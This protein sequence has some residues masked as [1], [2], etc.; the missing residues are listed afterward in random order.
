ME[1]QG[2]QLVLTSFFTVPVDLGAGRLGVRDINLEIYLRS[3]TF[4]PQPNPSQQCD[5]QDLLTSS[6]QALRDHRPKLTTATPSSY[7]DLCTA[8]LGRLH[9]EIHL[10]VSNHRGRSG[11][12]NERSD[13]VNKSAAKL[14]VR[15]F[16]SSSGFRFVG[17]FYDL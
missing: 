8:Y 13:I 14:H 7:P 12:L 4:N 2:S 15:D 9:L 10:G 6:V 3:T 17:V 16:E 11:Y 5:L 1:R